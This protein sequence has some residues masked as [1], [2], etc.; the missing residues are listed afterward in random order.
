MNA[1]SVNDLAFCKAS[2]N[3]FSIEDNS[4]H[5]WTMHL[6]SLRLLTH[7]SF[8]Q[9]NNFFK[10]KYKK[11]FEDFLKGLQKFLLVSGSKCKMNMLSQ[12]GQNTKASLSQIKVKPESENISPPNSFLQYIHLI[13]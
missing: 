13:D 11:F 9:K 2:R 7:L 10:N 5:I 12:K 8:L 6:N 3:L 4:P 1:L